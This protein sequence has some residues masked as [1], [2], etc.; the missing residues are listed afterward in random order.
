MA[1]V[2][3]AFSAYGQ[4][5][6]DNLSTSINTFDP[7]GNAG[8]V[9]RARR[10]VGLFP[11]DVA[12]QRTRGYQLLGLRTDTTG[13][14]STILPGYLSVPRLTT[15]HSYTLPGLDVPRQYESAF[16]RYGGFEIRAASRYRAYLPDTISRRQ[17]LI[18]ATSMSA[19][20]RRAMWRHGTLTLDRPAVIDRMPAVKDEFPEWS[21]GTA[22]SD[23][24][25]SSSIVD[26]QSVQRRAWVQFSERSYRLALRSFESART[27]APTDHKSRAGALFCLVFLDSMR[28]AETVLDELVT[29]EKNDLFAFDIDLRTF[30]PDESYITPIRL[31]LSR[32]EQDQD[33][34]GATALR[35]FVLWYFGEREEA[36]LAALGIARRAPGSPYAGWAAG[37]S[38]MIN[39]S[40]QVAPGV[41]SGG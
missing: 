30:C 26:Y 20:I 33:D 15:G 14:S 4:E 18:L 8:P 38:A 6:G 11:S 12:R 19:P 40:S 27:L 32:Y 3:V 23:L 28:A 22:L 9:D 2:L 41:G 36:R 25:Y 10:E 34:A 37:M 29:R 5:Q 16:S 7:F 24:L 13:L 35:A 21:G 17:Q 39:G 1:V 31:A